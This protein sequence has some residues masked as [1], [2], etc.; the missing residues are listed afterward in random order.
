VFGK[1]VQGMDVVKKILAGRTDG[2]T[3]VPS[4]KGQI[5][6]PAVKIISMK[7]M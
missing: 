5:L 6:N 4:M 1:V 2:A 3:N 7:R